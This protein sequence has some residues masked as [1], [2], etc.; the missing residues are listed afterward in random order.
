MI[1]K[2]AAWTAATH[3][4]GFLRDALVRA[5]N[6]RITRRHV[7]MVAALHVGM[8]VAFIEVG[9][10]FAARGIRPVDREAIKR[11]ADDR[12]VLACRFLER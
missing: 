6:V 5:E 1:L 10:R 12:R 7:I 4:I 2:S 3:E 8:A 9:G 11:E